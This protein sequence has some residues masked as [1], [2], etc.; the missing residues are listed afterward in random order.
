MTL[1]S[2]PA[3]NLSWRDVRE[4]VIGRI[5]NTREYR[6]DE[7]GDMSVL[8]LNLLPGQYMS[9]PKDDRLVSCISHICSARP[10]M[11]SF[12]YWHG[13]YLINGY[14]FELLTPLNWA[15]H[16]STPVLSCKPCL[17]MIKLSKY[18]TYTAQ[19]LQF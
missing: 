16:S 19:P 18:A 17:Q 1:V 4:V 11:I 13:C 9:L 3:A 12:K 15:H 14:G 6:L 7:S 8:S 2:D 10:V 5:R